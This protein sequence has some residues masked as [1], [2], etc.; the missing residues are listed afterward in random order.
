MANT[1]LGATGLLHVIQLKKSEVISL[2]LTHGVVVDSNAPDMEI[3]VRV[4]DLAKKSKSFYNAFMQLLLDKNVVQSVYSSMDGYS[5]ATGG[6]FY[7]PTTFNIGEST[8]TTAGLD[9][10]K[11]ENKKLALCGGSS[12]SS[13]T[14]SS[15]GSKWLTEGLNLLQTGFN[16][17]LQLDTNKTKR[18]LANASVAVAQSGGVVSGNTPPPSSN[19]ALYVVLGVVGV[20]VIGLV[21]YLATKKKA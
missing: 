4:T 20:S 6:T 14:T 10:T 9:C 1:T 8:S 16:G 5:N 15:G 7:M 2:L 12:A 13:S 19:T 3:A 17:Y 18:E 21:I 11:S